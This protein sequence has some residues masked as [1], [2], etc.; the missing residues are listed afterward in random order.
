MVYTTFACMSRVG[1]QK[2][3]NWPGFWGRS[4]S[5][6]IGPGLAT[7]DVALVGYGL[8]SYPGTMDRGLNMVQARR[9]QRAIFVITC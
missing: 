2:Q 5:D 4:L 6:D 9:S 1:P 3:A 7:E 8:S